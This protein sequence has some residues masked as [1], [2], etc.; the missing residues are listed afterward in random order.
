MIVAAALGIVAVTLT[1][2]A[3]DEL[4]AGSAPEQS[5]LAMIVAGVAA[6]VLIPLG[7]AKHRAGSA[8]KSHA[9]KG[10]GTLSGIGAALGFI[11]LLGLLANE[12]LGW[13]W[14]DRAAALGIAAIAGAEAV[15][16]LR[17]RPTV[18]SSPSSRPTLL[19]RLFS[20]DHSRSG[21]E[22]SPWGLTA[23][24]YCV[25]ALM[26][27]LAISIADALLGHRII[28]IGLLIVGPCCAIFGG[29]WF[30][31]AIIGV[32]AV[33]LGVVLSIP[34]GIWGS[35]AQL[36]LVGAVFLVALVSTFGA[37]IVEARG[38]CH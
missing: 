18:V 14:A 6:V 16:V 31:T 21:Q 10:D 11:A 37:A 8:L 38:P 19:T 17:K 22:T 15:R 23:R 30:Q 12:F 29:R 9:L 28:L 35:A 20:N 34:D 33:S 26:L 32:A 36:E 5:V 24:Q 25:I 1:V 3:I 2:A 13:W 27:C 7:I 4:W